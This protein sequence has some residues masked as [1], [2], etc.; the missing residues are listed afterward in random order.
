[1]KVTLE[2]EVIWARSP[3]ERMRQI[4]SILKTLYG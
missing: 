3:D 1:M 4:P 2:K